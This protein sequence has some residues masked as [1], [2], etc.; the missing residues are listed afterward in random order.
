MK[1]TNVISKIREITINVDCKN[2]L[3]EAGIHPYEGI[4]IYLQNGSLLI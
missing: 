2:F 3:K 1:K 4:N